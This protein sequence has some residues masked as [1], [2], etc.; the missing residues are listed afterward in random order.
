[1]LIA[2]S[3][4]PNLS[5]KTIGSGPAKG[6]QSW[7]VDVESLSGA[8]AAIHVQFKGPRADETKYYYRP[9]D[10]AWVSETGRVLSAKLASLIPESVL[11]KAFYYL[12]ITP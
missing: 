8:D 3:D 4:R 6:K 11:L 10:G 2:A 7:R 12:G 5:S 1:M 9:S